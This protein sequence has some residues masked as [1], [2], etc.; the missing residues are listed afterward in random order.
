[1]MSDRMSDTPA[2][3]PTAD[4]LDEFGEKLRAFNALRKSDR[5]AAD[6]ILTQLGGNGPVEQ[7][8]VRDLGLPRPIYIASRFDEAHRLVM[9]SLEVLKRN[10]SRSVRLEEGI[11]PLRALAAIVVQFFMRQ[12]VQRYIASAISGLD[13]LYTRRSTWTTKGSVEAD[14]LQRARLQVARVAPAYKGKKASLPSFLLG[15]AAISSALSGLQTA[16]DTVRENWILILV[17]TA[18]ILALLL[19]SAWCALRAAAVAHNRIRLTT[20]AP[21]RALYDVVGAA[22]TPPADKSFTFALYA[23]VAMAVAWI[24][25]PVGLYFLFN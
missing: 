3:Q 11:G 14:M 23:L 22:G 6:A 25:V 19:G 15:G 10:G 24:V 7:A 20:E 5:A 18:A 1:M 2:P 12:M 4:V 8:I 17:T 16:A 9:K 21:L 13:D